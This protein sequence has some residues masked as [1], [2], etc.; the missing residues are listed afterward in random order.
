MASRGRE[1]VVLVEPDGDF[2]F[3]RLAPYWN[4][5]RHFF[6]PSPLFVLFFHCDAKLAAARTR[7]VNVV[8][9]PIDRF[10]R[11]DGQFG[12]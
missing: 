6:G 3:Y 9:G 12:L 10:L 7:V 1:R 8:G 11:K 4:V 2:L 5:D